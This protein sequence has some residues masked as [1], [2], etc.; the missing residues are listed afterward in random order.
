MNAE[1]S[2][3]VLYVEDN[4]DHAY[5]VL[6]GLR[7]QSGISDVRS[8]EHGADA[9]DYLFRRGVYSDPKTSPRP[10]LVLLD[11]RLP[12]FDGLEILKSIKS[13]EQLMD[14]PVII[15][16]SSEAEDDIRQAYELHANGYLVKPI[17]FEKLSQMLSDVVSYWA[18]CN[19]VPRERRLATSV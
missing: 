4:A 7:Q 3:T 14:I 5:L 17:D 8:I 12:K 9:L 11:L 2:R 18:T 6:R 16:T 10:A 15:L 13:N 1:A 19:H